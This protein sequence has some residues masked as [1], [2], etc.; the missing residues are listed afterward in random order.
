MAIFTEQIQAAAD[1]CTRITG[2]APSWNNTDTTIAV[3]DD[4]ASSNYNGAFRFSGV[5]IPQGATISAATVTVKASNTNSSIS[6]ISFFS[7]ENVDNAT[8]I[9]S[10]A[11]FDS[12]SLT[13]LISWTLSSFVAN[14]TYT[15]TDISSE[16]QTVVNRIGW[17]SGNA[18]QIFWYNS[19]STS[20]AFRKIFSYDNLPANSMSLS[21][22]YTTPAPSAPYGQPT[23]FSVSNPSIGIQHKIIGY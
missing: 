23:A 19:N 15:S 16:I 22:T 17:V 14:T 12:R 18:L 3:G 5:T 6:A 21:I 20:G 2:A 13:G 9:T 10:G 11:D 4:G 1:D 7:C 8:Q